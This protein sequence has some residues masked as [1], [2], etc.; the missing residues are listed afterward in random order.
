MTG[1]TLH[2]K[3]QGTKWIQ[4]N[5]IWKWQARVDVKTWWSVTQNCRYDS[6]K[7]FLQL[8]KRACV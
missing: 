2:K 3:E 1:I 7:V 8:G 6:H 4:T 5:S